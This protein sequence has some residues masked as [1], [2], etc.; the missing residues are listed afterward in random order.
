MRRPAKQGKTTP[1]GLALFAALAIMSVG[2]QSD[3]A[4]ERSAEYN[5]AQRMRTSVNWRDGI[6]VNALPAKSD[7]GFTTTLK[8]IFGGAEN[9]EPETPPPVLKR[10]A[11]E[12]TTAPAS[13]LRVTWLGHSTLLLEVDGYRVLLDPI[14]GKRASPFS[15]AGPARFHPTPLPKTEILKMRI[16]A[17]LISHDHYDHLDEKTI[18]WIQKTGVRFL[19]PLGVGAHLQGWGVAPAQITELD[20]WEEVRLPGVDGAELRLVATPARHF[21]GRGLTDR[22]TTLW[23]SWS[24]LGPR[25]RVFFSGDTALFPGFRDIGERF[26]PFDLTMMEVGAY[27]QNW[28]DV[29]MGPEQA[30]KAHEMVRGKVL[31]PVHW[32]T[33]NLGLHAWTEPIERTLVAAERRGVRALTPRPGESLEPSQPGD[34]VRWWPA[35]PWQT[36]EAYPVH[37]TGLEPEDVAKSEWIQANETN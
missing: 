31:L 24:I 2:C 35:V 4:A 22:D 15:F 18:R 23:T 5:R 30:V 33:F 36:A 6:F 16:D 3:T 17:V 13:G 32:G 12:F 11:E 20:W 37:S 19:V 34:L 7:V 28:P 10:T 14:W 25:H 29:H 21:S 9:R 26:G 1:A 27:N 8:F